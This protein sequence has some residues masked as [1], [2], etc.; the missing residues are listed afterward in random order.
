MTSQIPKMPHLI[1][2]LFRQI[3]SHPKFNELGTTTLNDYYTLKSLWWAFENGYNSWF[4]QVWRKLY[5]D[6]ETNID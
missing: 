5:V 1:T 2:D 3:E 6:W 4:R